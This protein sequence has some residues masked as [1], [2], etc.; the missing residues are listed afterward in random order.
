MMRRLMP[1]AMQPC[2][3]DQFQFRPALAR[4]FPCEVLNDA[5]RDAVRRNTSL[6][7]AHGITFGKRRSFS[8]NGWASQKAEWAHEKARE[9][10]SRAFVGETSVQQRNSCLLA[11]LSTAAHAAGDCGISSVFV[12]APISDKP[13]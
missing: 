10:V 1:M 5:N 4:I 8:Q 12:R 9:A 6:L 3:L 2:D 7:H 11:T 13:R